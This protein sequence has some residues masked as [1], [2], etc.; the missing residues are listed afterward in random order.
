MVVARRA[1]VCARRSCADRCCACTGRCSDRWQATST[2]WPDDMRRN[3]LPPT[4]VL[5]TENGRAV[6]E[7]A[8][9]ARAL[10]QARRRRRSA[11]RAGAQDVRLRRRSARGR[12]F[13]YTTARRRSSAESRCRRSSQRRLRRRLRRC[14]RRGI[15]R[16]RARR[17]AAA[18]ASGHRAGGCCACVDLTAR[19]GGPR[20]RRPV[21]VVRRL[22]DPRRRNAFVQ[23]RRDLLFASGAQPLH[24]GARPRR[25]S[26]ARAADARS[27]CAS[28][29]AP[30][31]S[32][33]APRN[34]SIRCAGPS[35]IGRSI[36]L[37]TA[38]NS[39]SGAG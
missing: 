27:R 29:C 14:C 24:V 28:G 36:P 9:A 16:L 20:H 3:E 32:A 39:A 21:G 15:A 19:L 22:L 34:T 11:D 38:S 5:R 7:L 2:K 23:Q 4:G 13:R 37:R 35:S 1:G 10:D 12:R 17:R 26:G 33:A 25:R 8:T 31:R 6:V 18:A 30:P